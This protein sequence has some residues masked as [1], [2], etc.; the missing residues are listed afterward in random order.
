MD[1]LRAV[2]TRVDHRSQLIMMGDFKQNDTNKIVT[3]FERFCRALEGI[4]AFEWVQLHDEDQQ[5]N[6]NISEINR[7]L[8][9]LGN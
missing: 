2:I 5:R 6:G 9:L 7:R 4:H 8:D 3:D 1:V